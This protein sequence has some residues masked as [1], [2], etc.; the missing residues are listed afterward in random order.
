V[1]AEGHKR[2][3]PSLKPSCKGKVSDAL[4]KMLGRCLRDVGIT[5][6]R[7]TMYSF[8]HTMKMLLEEARVEP[9]LLKRIL[10]HASGDGSITDG[11]GVELPLG[12]VAEAFSKVKFPAI[13][14]AYWRPGVSSL[15]RASGLKSSAD[16]RP[17]APA[18]G[19]SSPSS[20]CSTP[21][22]SRKHKTPAV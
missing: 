7:K 1:K 21:S 5:E 10:G 20:P 16:S 19:V 3:F 11:Y 18:V 6:S 17:G 8:R 15:R 12:V 13:P 14:A 2:L 9:K 4:L 22:H